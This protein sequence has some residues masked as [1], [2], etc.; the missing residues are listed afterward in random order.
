MT[1]T[2]YVPMAPTLEE[3]ITMFTACKAGFDQMEFALTT[4][5]TDALQAEYREAQG[6]YARAMV[7]LGEKIDAA[8]GD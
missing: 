4:W 6:R 5:R 2:I 1:E 3:A 8:R 7:Y